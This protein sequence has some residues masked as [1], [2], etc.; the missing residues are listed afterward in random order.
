MECWFHYPY[1]FTNLLVDRDKRN[2]CRS[3]EV[4]VTLSCDERNESPQLGIL[5]VLD[6]DKEHFGLPLLEL[7]MTNILPCSV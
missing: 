2:C 3:R 4:A 1:Q 5:V 6:D 7:I